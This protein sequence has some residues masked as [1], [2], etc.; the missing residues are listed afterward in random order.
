MRLLVSVRDVRDAR[1]AVRGGADI[2]DAKDPRRGALGPVT[3]RILA[4]IRAAVP[5]AIMANT[6][7]RGWLTQFGTSS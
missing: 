7:T 5:S 6:A 1:A 2:V 3:H 4:R